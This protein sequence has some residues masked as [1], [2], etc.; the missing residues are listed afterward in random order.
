[1]EREPRGD[2]NPD[3]HDVPVDEDV[4]ALMEQLSR[5]T[6]GRQ[7]RLA[8]GTALALQLG[9]RRSNDLEYFMHGDRIDATAIMCVVD[10]LTP[11]IGRAEIVL[12]ESG[13]LDLVV[14]GA[15][16]KVSFIAYPF[17]PRHEPLEIHGQQCSRVIEVA[18]MK[19]YAIGRRAAARD[20]VDVEASLSFGGLGLGE[21]VEEAR[22]RFVV[23]DEPVFSERLFLQQ[24]VDTSDLTDAAGLA[25]IRSSWPDV[26]RSLRHAVATYVRSRLP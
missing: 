14:G 1:M 23:D 3:E 20:Y 10:S 4:I 26:E 9:H 25:L 11:T 8:G 2:T 24:L 13:Q 7:F 17:A 19:A 12:A 5:T 15:R 21:I 6:I 16:R 22:N 18:A